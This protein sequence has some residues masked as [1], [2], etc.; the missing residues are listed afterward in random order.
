[1]WLVEEGEIS[2]SPMERMKPPIVPEQPVPVLPDDALEKLLAACKAGTTFEDLRDE[3]VIRL[4]MD[5]GMR[6]AEM[7]GLTV[8]DVDL[9]A[10]VAHVLGKGRR[11]RACPFGAKK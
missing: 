9:D 6:L 8:E 10:R 11:R 7:A 3:V 4:F 1:K 2:S 5:T